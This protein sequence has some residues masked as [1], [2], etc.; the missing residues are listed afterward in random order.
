MKN[1]IDSFIL[2]IKE[3]PEFAGKIGALSAK[4]EVVA[5]AKAAGLDLC[6]EDIDQ[7]N[8]LLMEEYIESIQQSGSAGKL[9]AR[10]LEDKDFAEQIISQNEA[11]SVIEIAEK[12]GIMI[13][14]GD[15]DEVKRTLSLL[16]G[17]QISGATGELSEEDLE[18]VA[19]GVI[20]TSVTDFALTALLITGT[21]S[22]FSVSATVV[23]SASIIDHLQKK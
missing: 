4:S 23:L 3:D 11:D 21:V 17:S 10:M 16:S 15:V 6:E 14:A 2:K 13:T 20:F 1:A 22:V 7:V 12:A 9:L 5:E 8:K 18:Q 19:G